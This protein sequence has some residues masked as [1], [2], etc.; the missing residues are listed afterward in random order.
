MLNP[1]DTFL[2]PKPGQIEHLWIVLTHPDED[3]LAV[4]VNVT[5]WR[6]SADQTLVLV[7]GDHPFITKKSVVHYDDARKMP[8]DRIEQ[9][10]QQGASSFVCKAH[11]ACTYKLMDRIKQGLLD[12]KR[13][14]NGIKA[15]CR[16]IW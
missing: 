4:C 3:G 13:T 2:L 16:S 7:P 1:G 14:P 12:S 5:S 6:P 9:L 10:L 15:F 11:Y 8:L